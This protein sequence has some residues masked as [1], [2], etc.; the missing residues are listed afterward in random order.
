M[1]KREIKEII[2]S[3]QELP[4][5]MLKKQVMEQGVAPEVFEEAWTEAMREKALRTIEAH[6]EVGSEGKLIIA[7]LCITIFGAILNGLFGAFWYRGDVPFYMYI[8]EYISTFTDSALA[9]HFAAM[10]LGAAGSFKRSVGL[11][12]FFFVISIILKIAGPGVVLFGMGT[13]IL[14]GGLYMIS[15]VFNTGAIKTF[16]LVVLQFVFIVLINLGAYGLYRLF[17][18][19]R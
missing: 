8:N 2:L 1:D 17:L 18:M 12:V 10:V 5:D 15:R 14:I 3:Y 9:L 6:Q 7:F 19:F 4:R 13:F 11:A 16:L